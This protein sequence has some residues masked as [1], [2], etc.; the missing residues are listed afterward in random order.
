M[1]VLAA[2]GCTTTEIKLILQKD[3]GVN[4]SYTSITQYG[5]TVYIGVAMVYPH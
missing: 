1:S 3:Y 5:S 4:L 2:S